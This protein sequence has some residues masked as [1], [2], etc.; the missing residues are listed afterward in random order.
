METPPLPGD[1]KSFIAD[2]LA[3]PSL[4]SYSRA[5]TIVEDV[6]ELVIA[7]PNPISETDQL[8]LRICAAYRTRC[9]EAIAYFTREAAEQEHKKYE[10]AASNKLHKVNRTQLK[11]KQKNKRKGRLYK[12]DSG[13][14][15]AAALEALRLAEFL[16]EQERENE[17]KVHFS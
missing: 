14:H 9:E 8:L 5:L 11:D 16:E 6:V 4:S 7:S 2:I 17:K 13:E 1:L 10:R 12:I 3:T 15:V